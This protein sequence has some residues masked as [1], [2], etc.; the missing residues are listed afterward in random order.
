MEWGRGVFS[1]KWAK[2]VIRLEKKGNIE[3]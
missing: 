2:I 3:V 1:S